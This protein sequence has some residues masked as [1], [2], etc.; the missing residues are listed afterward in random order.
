MD[1]GKHADSEAEVHHHV[2]IREF[3]NIELCKCFGISRPTG[4][5]S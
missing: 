1:N 5:A 3:T 2:P 4:E